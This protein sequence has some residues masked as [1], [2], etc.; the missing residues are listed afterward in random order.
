MIA[1]KFY[2]LDKVGSQFYNSFEI[3]VLVLEL[4]VFIM[5]YKIGVYFN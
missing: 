3:S 2:I 5:D 4:L 1:T